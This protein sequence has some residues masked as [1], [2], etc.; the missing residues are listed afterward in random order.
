MTAYP[1][2]SVHNLIVKIGQLGNWYGFLIRMCLSF[3][4]LNLFGILSEYCSNR[5]PS[6]PFLYEVASHVKNCHFADY[7]I[8]IIII[9]ITSYR[10]SA[11]V[12]ETGG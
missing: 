7:Y 11:T 8:I 6:A 9:I 2:V 4:I 1:N 5:R 10:Y 12:A 3:K